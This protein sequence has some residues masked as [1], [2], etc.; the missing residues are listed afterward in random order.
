MQ[1]I[2]VKDLTGDLRFLHWSLLVCYAA[3]CGKQLPTFWRSLLPS[4]S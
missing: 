4:Q 3:L 1:C 2:P